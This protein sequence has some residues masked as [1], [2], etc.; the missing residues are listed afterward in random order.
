MPMCAHTWLGILRGLHTLQDCKSHRQSQHHS[1]GVRKAIL[2][3]IGAL[4]VIG[5]G[6]HVATNEAIMPTITLLM[7]ARPGTGSIAAVQDML[8]VWMVRGLL[9]LPLSLS[10]FPSWGKCGGSGGVP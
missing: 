10:H 6:G 2:Q 9:L 7:E 1:Y 5:G 3:E 4:C 8:P